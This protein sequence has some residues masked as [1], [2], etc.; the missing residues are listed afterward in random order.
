[1][2]YFILPQGLE[3]TDWMQ[4]VLWKDGKQG[5][6]GSMCPAS[7]QTL[8]AAEPLKTEYDKGADSLTCACVGVWRCT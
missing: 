8:S 1:M 6:R 2:L 7:L 3:K 5:Q 4:S